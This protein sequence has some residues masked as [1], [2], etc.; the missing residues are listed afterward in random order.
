MAA[1]LGLTLLAPGAALA[2]PDKA[3]ADPV[4]TKVSKE[5]GTAILTG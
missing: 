1:G 5:V 3:G 2:A 4:L